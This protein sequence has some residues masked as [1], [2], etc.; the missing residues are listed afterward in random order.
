MSQSLK[1]SSTRGNE[2]MISVAHFSI[3]VS[4]I[5][6]STGFSTEVL[7]CRHWAFGQARCRLLRPARHGEAMDQGGRL[8]Y[9]IL[10]DSPLEGDGF[11]LLV[12]RHKSR[13]FPE[14]SGHCGV[15]AGS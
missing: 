1:E 14:H 5:A 3:P 8:L 6:K 13:G 4:D 10:T 9:W 7:G 2:Q 12:P 11:E 15:L